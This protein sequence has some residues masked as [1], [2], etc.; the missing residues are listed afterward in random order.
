MN[1]VECGNGILKEIA[2]GPWGQLTLRTVRPGCSTEPHRH[3]NTE[4]VWWVVE[5]DAVVTVGAFEL[6]PGRRETVRVGAGVRHSVR[7]EGEGDVVFV[8]WSDKTY[9][10]QEKIVD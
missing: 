8:F 3:P 9:E 6:R 2:R 5:G 1:E 7:N 10:E 4:E